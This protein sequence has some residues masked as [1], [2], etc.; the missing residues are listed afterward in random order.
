MLVDCISSRVSDEEKEQMK[1][2]IE[3]KIYIAVWTLANQDS[4][5]EIGNLF[6]LE[7]STVCFI[8]HSICHILASLRFEYIKWPSAHQQQLTSRVVYRQHGFPNCIGFVDGCHIQILGPARNPVDYYN[9]KEVHSIILQAVCNEKLEFINIYLGH[10]GRAHDARV[11]RE[12][13]LSDELL[14]LVSS[15]NH[16]LGDSAYTLGPRLLTPYRDNGHLLDSQKKYNKVHA[17]SR[18][19]IKRAFGRLKGKFRRL[20]YLDLHKTEISTVIVAAACVLHNFIL[21]HEPL[22]ATIDI[23]QEQEDVIILQ[24][25][26]GIE[27]RDLIADLVSHQ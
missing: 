11:F 10:T 12:S 7:K 19:Y 1:I 20:K 24:N 6:G 15:E 3:K 22:D 14:N 21:L 17:S 2:P 26:T 8:F 13:Q 4:Y 25:L 27:K 9:R 16:I 5:R 23:Q 18:A